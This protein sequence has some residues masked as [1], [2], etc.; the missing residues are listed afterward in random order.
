MSVI[1]TPKNIFTGVFDFV[2]N[3][4][5]EQ[6]DSE[7]VDMWT[8]EEVRDS[9]EKLC[10]TLAP[11]DTKTAA[12][13]TKTKA[14][15]PKAAKNKGP[16]KPRSSYNFFCSEQRSALKEQ[17]PKATSGELQ[18]LLGASWRKLDEEG[19]KKYQ[20]LAT[21]D[22]ERF[23]SESEESSSDSEGEPAPKT[24]PK[25]KKPKSAY[26]IFCDEKREEV[27]KNHPDLDFGGLSKELGRLWKEDKEA[28]ILYK[29]IHAAR[30][31]VTAPPPKADFFEKKTKK[32]PSTKPSSSKGKVES[33]KEKG[34]TEPE[35]KPKRKVTPYV[36]YCRETRANMKKKNPTLKYAEITKLL[37]SSWKSLSK[38]EQGEWKKKLD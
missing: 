18:T 24:K 22:K 20:E 17:N 5:E 7:L 28:Q 30:K 33:S 34:P 27:K 2:Q 14:T 11:P 15:K 4:L 1:S 29:K 35:T 6:G 8:S 12:P 3:F 13:E 16:K 21:K 26:M 10:A 19:K 38:E 37:S 36:L 32:A 25:T 9:L 31:A 23:K